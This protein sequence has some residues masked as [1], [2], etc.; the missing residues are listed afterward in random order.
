MRSLRSVSLLVAV[1]VACGPKP[2][3]SITPTLPGD[4][5]THVAKPT[6]PPPGP[7][8]DD[9]WAG[10][11]DLIATP[12][13]K[14][15]Q[16]LDLPEVKR[17]TLPNGLKVLIVKD[18]RLPIVSMQLAVRAGRADEP[19][20]RLGVSE[21]AA[22]M[23]VKGTTRRKALDIAKAIDF[24]GGG[25]GV[26]ASFEATI[27]SCKVL[28]KNTNVC[29]DLLPDVMLNPSFPTDEMARVREQLL[30]GVRSR[31]DD[32]GTMASI[33]VQNLLW[34]N[35]HVRG[36][37]TDEASVKAITRDDLVAWHKA[38]FAPDNALLAIA[39]DVDPA[40]LEKDL[41][42]AFG[43]W[44]KRAVPP[45]PAYA[46]PKQ[47][48][49]RIRLVDKPKQTQTQIRI[50]QL[51]IRHS[52]PRFFDSL[53][54]NYTL[55]GGAFSSRLMKVVRSAGGKT[56]GASSAFDRNL[57]RG[58]FV[59]STFT[60]NAEAVNTAK[61][62]LGEIA[63][64]AKDGP[65]ESEVSDAIAN[66]AGSYA[67]RFEGADDV[68]SALLG[69]ELHGFGEEY[70]ENYAL[71]VGKVDAASA[72][73]AAHDI[74]APD[75]VVIVMVGDAAELKPLLDKEGW[76][77]DLVKFTDPIG[78]GSGAVAP[79]PP[80]DPKAEA[81]GRAILDDALKAKGGA[82]KLK[83]LK[84]I[85][86]KASGTITGQGQTLDIEIERR[87]AL[88]DQIRVDVT[89]AHQIQVAYAVAKGAGWQK[90]PQGVADVPAEQLDQ[91][92]HQRWTDPEFVLLR[93]LEKGAVVR[94]LP[95]QTDKG[96]A[97]ALV[98]ITSADGAHT[99]TL[100]IDKKTKLIKQLA[101]PDQGDVS[102]DMFDDY[103]DVGGIKIAHKRASKNGAEELSLTVDKIELNPAM[104][105]ALF[106]RPAK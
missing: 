19:R 51:G 85:D 17:F 10:R 22:D 7:K 90:S 106:A 18:T 15:P 34:G 84:G 78:G 9:P 73:A 52:D 21:F 68:T 72:K 2:T 44:K 12:A 46:D 3:P 27:A 36:W 26:D 93:H 24:V 103:K 54:W 101:Y 16:K 47:E 86:M 60:R 96:V 98:N 43:G 5:D 4:G 69:A 50:A 74:L 28:T 14:P 97:Y 95:D 53:V 41:G 58:T 82:D 30:G 65:T 104:D 45:H 35:E 8:V 77:Y 57:D 62:V 71:R 1:L 83:A 76:H 42:K 80:V 25:L 79:P 38:W 100:F 6:E 66:I 94:A 11:T 59:A 40:K 70:V 48:G 75:K 87:F 13:V 31:L 23:L 67:V 32:A 92:D 81:A 20:A 88:P 91:L 89:I 55:G 99:V 105:A 61:L 37:V 63:K 102:F 64:M 49:I 56:Y 29:L 39:G 33:Q